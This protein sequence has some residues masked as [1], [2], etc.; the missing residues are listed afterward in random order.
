[1]TMTTNFSIFR[2]TFL[3]EKK[4]E[5]AFYA[6]TYVVKCKMSRPVVWT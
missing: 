6:L 4:K 5:F 2:L 3:N 1:M